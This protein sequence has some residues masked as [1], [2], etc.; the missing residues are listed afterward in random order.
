M[1]SKLSKMLLSVAT[2]ALVCSSLAARA[3]DPTYQ[4][5]VTLLKTVYLPDITGDFDHFAVDQKRNHLFVSAE[6]HHSIEMFDLRTGEHLQSLS[7]FKTP[8]SLAFDAQKDELLICDGGDSAL[9][10]LDPSDYHRIARI[11]LIDGSV[12]GKGD[13][14]D[15]AITM[16]RRGSIT[17]GM[18]A[19]PPTC[20]IR[21]SRSSRPTKERSSITS[22]FPAIISRAWSSTMP[23][24]ACM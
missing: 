19:V 22:R 7:G 5:P 10:L 18:A 14:P 3:A 20:P 13:S 12:T 8:H 9:V 4:Q 21:P 2:A 1:R 11:P 23:V 17:S 16:R 24:T 15:A 6:V